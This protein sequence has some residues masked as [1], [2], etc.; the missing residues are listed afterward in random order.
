MGEI[1]SAAQLINRG[2]GSIYLC[3]R[4]SCREMETVK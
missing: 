2:A 1:V 4:Q 3:L